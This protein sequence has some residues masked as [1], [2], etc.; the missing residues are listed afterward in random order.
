ML[1]FLE[2]TIILLIFKIV[3]FFSYKDKVNDKCFSNSSGTILGDS[4]VLTAK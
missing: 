1:K 4:K 2:L 3:R